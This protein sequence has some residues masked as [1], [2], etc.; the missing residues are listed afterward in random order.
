MLKKLKALK[1]KLSKTLSSSSIVVY[2]KASKLKISSFRRFLT[3]KTNTK[4]KRA[5]FFAGKHSIAKQ[6]KGKQCL[7]CNN[8]LLPI[9]NFCYF[10]GQANDTS[11]L[12]LWSFLGALFGN[13]FSYDGK[14]FNT[15]KNLIFRPG[16]ISSDYIEGK[17][18]RYSNPFKFYFT[19]S[20]VF[21]LVLGLNMKIEDLKE[22]RSN[23]VKTSTSDMIRSLMSDEDSKEFDKAIKVTDS[24]LKRNDIQIGGEEIKIDS[25]R[26]NVAELSNSLSNSLK[27]ENTFFDNIGKMIDYSKS[28]DKSKRTIAQVLDSLKIE[29]SFMNRFYLDKTKHITNELDYGDGISGFARKGVSYSPIILFILLPFFTLFLRIIYI[30]GKHNYLGH[31]IFVFNTQTVFFL[32][33]ILITIYDIFSKVNDYR[34]MMF[35]FY[36]Y[37]HF[38]LKRFNN[39]GH[40]K[41]FLKSIILNVLF[42]ILSVIGFMAISVLSFV[43]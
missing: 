9:D 18:A 7:N 13:F 5:E 21:F 16:S 40:I 36:I 38:A 17:R 25:L 2:K 10:C 8:P 42:L 37:L 41:T 34:I 12:K 39:Q 32:L 31:L 28:V 26:N 33:L 3:L 20:I 19:I 14:F 30:R 43:F 15:L 1:S 29:D 27:S 35:V 22:L 6:V 24:V 4:E 23:K 11:K